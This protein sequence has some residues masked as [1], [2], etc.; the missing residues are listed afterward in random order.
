MGMQERS[1]RKNAISVSGMLAVHP[2]LNKLRHVA[3]E[4]ADKLIQNTTM[5][6]N[7]DRAVFGHHLMKMI[8]DTGSTKNFAISKEEADF[9][10][11]MAF[12]FHDLSRKN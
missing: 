12:V 2:S 9:H 10:L 4:D 7:A 1:K 6:K 5:D 8:Q 3:G 11:S